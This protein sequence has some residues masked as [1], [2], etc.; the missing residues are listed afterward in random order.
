[1]LLFVNIFTIFVVGFHQL[2]I[3]TI[4]IITLKSKNIMFKKAIYTTVLAVALSLSGC[5]TQGTGLLG[6]V[7]G[8]DNGSSSGGGL[9]GI[10]GG[11]LGSVVNANTAG[12]LLDMVIGHIKLNQSDLVGTWVYS[13]PGCAFTSENLL[14]KAGGSVAATKVKESLNSIYNSLGIANNNTYFVFAQ[15]GQ[16]EAKLRGIPLS[17]TYTF[18]SDDSKINLKT[19]LFTI[20][21]YVTRTTNGLAITM[22]SKKLLSVLQTITSLTGNNTLK[23]IGDLSKNF[24]GVRMGFDVV[25]YQ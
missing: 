12:G 16:F 9:G 19:M 20:P 2:E 6:N 8:G 22:E 21:A 23:T 1:M 13:G 5:G 10:L 17:G 24:D 25:R 11:V 7:L 15:N 3:I 18:D 4:Q 14:A